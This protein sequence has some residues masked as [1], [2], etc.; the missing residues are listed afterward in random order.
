M[1]SSSPGII[2]LGILAVLFGLIGAH[3]AK[4]YLQDQQVAAP[5]ATPVAETTVTV[6]LAIRDLPE[7]RTIALG[8]FTTV[9]L[10][11]EQIRDMN[12]PTSFMTKSSQ[13]LGRTLRTS[14]LKSQAFQPETFFPDG[15]GPNVASRLGP[16]ERAVSVPFDDSASQAGLVTPGATVDV[17]FRT[18]ADT[19]QLLPEAT[20]TLLEA[21]KVL[22]VDRETEEGATPV[23]ERGRS[24]QRTVTLAVTPL[25]AQALKVVEDRGTLTLVLRGMEGRQLVGVPEPEP[26]PVRG[27]QAT[28]DVEDLLSRAEENARPAAE[29]NLT[30]NDLAPMTLAQLLGIRNTSKPQK[31]EIYRRGQLTTVIYG[32][33]GRTVIQETPYGMPVAERPRSVEAQGVSHRHPSASPAPDDSAAADNRPCGCGSTAVTTSALVRQRVALSAG[34]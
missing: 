18:I 33:E 19:E 29:G 20:M 7:G 9:R 3:G 17:L 11:E 34:L 16:G 24:A 5:P 21:V 27:E 15:I 26:L 25:Q 32:D 23:T 10:T 28:D 1:R 8:D 31:L 6:P 12:L 22:A 13:I 2:F 30:G 14:V 4:K